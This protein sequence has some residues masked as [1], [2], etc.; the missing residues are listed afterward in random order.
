MSP[1]RERNGRRESWGFGGQIQDRGLTDLCSFE[2]MPA[3]SNITL[4][5]LMG[6]YFVEVK[7]DE[8]RAE[9]RGENVFTFRFNFHLSLGHVPLFVLRYSLHSTDT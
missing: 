8:W 1:C 9:I 4:S 7:G 5:G 6:V 2:V 3:I